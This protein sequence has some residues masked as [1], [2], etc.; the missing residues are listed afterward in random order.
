MKNHKMKPTRIAS[1]ARIQTFRRGEVT[2]S[3]QTANG[4]GMA[5]NLSCH[6]AL[7]N[8]SG[9]S[10]R[11]PSISVVRINANPIKKMLKSLAAPGTQDQS[12]INSRDDETGAPANGVW[13]VAHM[14]TSSAYSA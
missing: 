1:V 3:R 12:L 6:K 2:T 8:S 7:T 14:T 13:S 11:A 5:L 4:K 10:M 9:V